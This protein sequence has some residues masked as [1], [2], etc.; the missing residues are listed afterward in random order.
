[1][2]LWYWPG[3]L[4]FSKQQTLIRS[5]T[6]NSSRASQM[7]LLQQGGVKTSNCFPLLAEA[8]GLAPYIGWGEQCVQGSDGQLEL[9]RLDRPVVFRE[10]AWDGMSR[11]AAE[12]TV[13]LCAALWL[14]PREVT[15]KIS[16]LVL[17]RLGSMFL[18]S[19]ALIWRGSAS[20]KEGLGMC[21][22]PLS[23][24]RFPDSALWPASSL[25]C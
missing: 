1:M 8:G 6:R 14:P 5:L 4:A 24:C 23:V 18:R 7:P 11:R 22:R 17:T 19:E 9:K 15:S 16:L 3:C 25:N 21:I 10:G 2:S 12:G 13:T 20:C